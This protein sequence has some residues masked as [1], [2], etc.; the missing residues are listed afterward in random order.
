[1]IIIGKG[2]GMKKVIHLTEQDLYFI[3]YDSLERLI[4][5]GIDFNNDTHRMWYTPGKED[6]L[7]TSIASNPTVTERIINGI[8]IWS[9]FQRKTGDKRGD[10]NPALYAFKGEKGW[11]ISNEDRNL[12]ISQ[13]KLIIQ[14]FVSV[15]HYKATIVLP[16]TNKLNGYFA[17]WIKE[18]DQNVNIISNLIMKMSVEEVLDAIDMPN[19]AFHK[20]YG[21]GENFDSAFRRLQRYC[22]KMGGINELF[23]YHCVSDP[24]MREAIT[25]TM[26][27]DDREL[28]EY[29]ESINGQDILLIDDSVTYGKSLIEAANIIKQYYVPKSITV[30][31]LFSPLYNSDGVQLANH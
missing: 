2:L 9:V 15:H 24:K 18:K 21:N 25:Q 14:K 23:K 27:I 31:T 26:K 4:N 19:S 5:E 10:G 29:I 8:K 12:I 11:K 3:V 16:S 17:S 22:E 7:N 6:N 1:M 28:G 13:A 20:Q 30:L